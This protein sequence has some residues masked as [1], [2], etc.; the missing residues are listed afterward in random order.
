M[1]DWP[2][3]RSGD[4][5]TGAPGSAA[6]EVFDETLFLDEIFALC[7]RFNL[8]PPV[9]FQGTGVL[10]IGEDDRAAVFDAALTRFSRRRGDAGFGGAE[11]AF[12]VLATPELLISVQ[13]QD[14]AGVATC[15]VASAGGTV[16]EHRPLPDNMHRVTVVPSASGLARALRFSGLADHPVPVG[17][18]VTISA[19]Q[20]LDAGA[21]AARGDLSGAAEIL[22]RGGNEEARAAFLRLLV[23]PPTA[24]QVTVLD[25]PAPGRLEGTL[26]AWLDGG[27][28]G[29]WRVPAADIATLGTEAVVDAEAM[30]RILDI[31]AVARADL[32]AEITEGFDAGLDR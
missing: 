9:V 10:R 18:S 29:L 28:A 8:L 32:L 3:M 20:L 15:F 21:R 13:R 25:R 11:A 2:W 24:V 22:S 6:V 14:R 5:D 30:H 4:P 19:A 12:K 1:L 23:A 17:A 26:T 27:D 7:A 31:R 16:V